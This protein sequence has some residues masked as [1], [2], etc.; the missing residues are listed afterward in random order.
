MAIVTVKKEQFVTL[1][2]TLTPEEARFL[3]AMMQNTWADEES[4]EVSMREA[5]F[6]ELKQAGVQ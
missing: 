6:N 3:K 2:V 4:A 5:I 1:V